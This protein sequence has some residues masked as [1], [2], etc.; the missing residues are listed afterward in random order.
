MLD[1]D[2]HHA[3]ANTPLALCAAASCKCVDVCVCVCCKTNSS[4][5]EHMKLNEWMNE[6][7]FNGHFNWNGQRFSSF[8]SRLI[9]ICMPK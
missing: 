7:N 6:C 8:Q 5:V 4:V 2:S 3:H 1:F 9:A